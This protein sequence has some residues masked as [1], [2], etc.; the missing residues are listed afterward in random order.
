MS[1]TVLSLYVCERRDNGFTVPVFIQSAPDT[2]AGRD[3]LDALLRT[4]PE[5]GYVI[6]ELKKD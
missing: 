4:Y 2:K 6:R 3:N 5:G 1:E